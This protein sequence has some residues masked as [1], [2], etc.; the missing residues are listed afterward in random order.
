MNTIKQILEII[1][2]IDEN[3]VFEIEGNK[4]QSTMIIKSTVYGV[5]ITKLQEKG[6]CV[7]FSPNTFGGLIV[8]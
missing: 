8:F 7:M 6:Y 1:E 3:I 4:T 2:I 5:S